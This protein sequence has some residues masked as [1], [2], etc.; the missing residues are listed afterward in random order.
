MG[1]EGER[2][3]DGREGEER[4]KAPP[5]VMSGYAYGPEGHVRHHCFAG[6]RH[7]S[8]CKKVTSRVDSFCVLTIVVEIILVF[9]T[10]VRRL[11]HHFCAC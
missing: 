9:A 1:S 4:V 3:G 10:Y 11:L 6:D 2:E 8:I 5:D 7:R